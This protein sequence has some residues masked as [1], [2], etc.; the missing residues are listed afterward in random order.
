MAAVPLRDDRSHDWPRGLMD[1]ASDFESEDCE[2]ESRRGR[3]VF[4]MF[5]YAV[6][7][8]FMYVQFL[9]CLCMCDMKYVSLYVR[10]SIDIDIY[11]STHLN[12]LRHLHKIYTHK[13][14]LYIIYI[15]I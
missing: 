1:K 10:V 14:G 6:F 3:T 8:M 9:I 12:I 5:I 7:N 2:F 15:Y 13:L 11:I 4:N